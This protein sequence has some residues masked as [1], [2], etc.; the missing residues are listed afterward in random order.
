MGILEEDIGKLFRMGFT[1]K[2]G[3]T[4][5]GLYSIKRMVLK[6]RGDISLEEAGKNDK[7]NYV[8]RFAIKIPLLK[9]GSEAHSS[10]SPEEGGSRS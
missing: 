9:D 2:L 7:G 1:T 5:L 8:A 4:G 10:D 3:G 6:N